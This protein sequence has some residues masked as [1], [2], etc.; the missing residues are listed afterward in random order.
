MRRLLATVAFLFFFPAPAAAAFDPSFLVPRPQH[1]APGACGQ[2][3]FLRALRLAPNFDAGARELID[4]RWRGLG[5]PVT[6]SGSDVVVR[7]QNAGSHERYTLTVAASQIT[8]DAANAESVFDAAMTL[9]QLARPVRGGFVLPCVR[10]D[11]APA[12][13]WRIVSDDVSRGPLPT[14]RYFKERIRGLAALKLNGYSIYMEHVFADAAHPVVAPADAITP[15][16]LHDLRDYAARFHVALIPEQQ[17]LAHMHGTLRWEEFA[18][19]AETAHGWLLSP[20][21]AGTYKYLEPLLREVMRAVGKV[22]FVHLGSDEP[23]EL[24]RGQSLLMATDKGLAQTF[25][26]HVNHVAQIVRPFGARPMIWDDAVQ[27]DPA[28]LPLLPKNTVIV[29][30]HY[31]REKS[32]VPY[33]QRVAAAGLDQMVS[34]GA[35][36]W[37]EIFPRIDLAFDNIGRFVAAGK[38]A[39]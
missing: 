15:K 39:H 20:A 8:I 29:D 30:F 37:N 6:Q 32:F 28:I 9:A 7:T 25:A 11:D 31:G 19:L 2:R 1:I 16:Q 21:N 4:E 36:N 26:A 27:K 10:V 17:T 22:P 33:I 12:L 38:A 18:P 34:P 35:N 5:I 24:G 13:G 3:V 14:M 23:L